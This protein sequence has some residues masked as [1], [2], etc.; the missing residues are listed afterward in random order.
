VPRQPTRWRYLLPF[1]PGLLGLLVVACGQPPTGT[2]EV[3]TARPAAAEV[4][5]TD[6]CA[7]EHWVAA[8]TGAP[9]HG[10]LGRPDDVPF[11][12]ADGLARTFGDQTLRMVVS[13]RAAG[14]A[15]RVL[16]SN[17]FGAAPVTFGA[18][19]VAAQGAGADA[20]PG[21]MRALTFDGARSVT[22][23]AGGEVRS[24]PLDVAVA[25]FDRLLISFAVA[26][27]GVVLDHHQR[28]QTT[29]YAAPSGSGDHADDDSGAA[30]TEELGGWYAVT[31]LEVLAPRSTGVVVTLGDS[32]TD[33][34]GSSPNLDR[35]WPDRLQ[36]RL[37]LAGAPLAVVNAGIAGNHVVTSG[38]SSVTAIGP[39]AVER[40]DL[41]A[42]RVA[43]V[44][45]LFVFEGVNDLFMSGGEG[46]IAARVIAGYEQ[47]VAEARA[48][49][50][51]VIGATITPASMSGA[52]E[53]ARLQVN[54][55]I[56]TSGAYDAVVDFD[57]V[58]RDPAAPSRL[59]PEWDA[60][61]AHL[62]DAGYAAMAAAVP[63]DAFGGT[64]C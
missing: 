48:A 23:P 59:R 51:R 41:D 16:L 3:S 18:V 26:G 50:L 6:A 1:V 4:E 5:A 62:N 61:F 52:R 9:Q 32:I 46:D 56:R 21:T 12:D 53:D 13:S 39:S 27:T 15:L 19:T 25:P 60:G 11:G 31:G 33:G 35:R 42:L 2:G 20:V 10:S 34:V 40:L 8:W 54:E 57:A 22:V 29:S 44:T 47:I 14:S 58:T 45:D 38:L 63:L 28:A 55:W 30:F 24:D 64:G 7:G 43:G 37:L 49:G 36:E 17:R